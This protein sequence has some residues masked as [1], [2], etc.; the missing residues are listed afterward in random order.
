MRSNIQV[1]VR[2]IH[3]SKISAVVKLFK[4]WQFF[5]SWSV[6]SSASRLGVSPRCLESVP[7]SVQY[8]NQCLVYQSAYPGTALPERPSAAT[9]TNW[10]HLVQ[11]TNQRSVAIPI[12]V[13]CTNQLTLALPCQNDPW[14]QHV[15]IGI[16]WYKKQSYFPVLHYL[17]YFK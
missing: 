14:R 13:W 11:C 4:N 6:S 3:F 5:C 1:F 8:T 9:R 12:S 17:R 2:E 10:H 15:P 16:T 7:I